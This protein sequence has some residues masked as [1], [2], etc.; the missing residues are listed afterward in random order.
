MTKVRKTLILFVPVLLILMVS[1][2]LISRHDPEPQQFEKLELSFYVEDALT[3]PMVCQSY[4]LASVV[5]WGD[6]KF[7]LTNSVGRQQVGRFNVDSARVSLS[8]YAKYH[9]G[10]EASPQTNHDTGLRIELLGQ[11]V[12]INS[13]SRPSS[14]L[15]WENI[16]HDFWLRRVGFASE[17]RESD[18]QLLLALDLTNCLPKEA[19]QQ[20]TLSQTTP[21]SML[22]SSR[23]IV[24]NEMT[25]FF[26]FVE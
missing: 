25:T 15:S 18:C 26:S 5:F 2:F 3:D 24:Q 10:F 12:R 4:K 8:R 20:L 23:K 22:E 13:D 14:L 16:K 6:G 11:I 7:S 1:S 19:R 9:S 17:F 21:V